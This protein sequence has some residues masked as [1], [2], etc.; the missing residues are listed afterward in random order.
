MRPSGIA[1]FWK[2]TSGVTAIEYG[3]LALFVA[4]GIVASVTVLG[5]NLTASYEATGESFPDR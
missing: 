5:E 4:V 1:G 3:L 2:D